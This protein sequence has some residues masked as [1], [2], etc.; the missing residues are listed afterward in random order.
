MCQT[1][2][3]S[4]MS[5]ISSLC[6]SVATT[7]CKNPVILPASLLVPNC[8]S[9]TNCNLTGWEWK[10]KKKIFDSLKILCVI[11]FTS[12]AKWENELIRSLEQFAS[13]GT[14]DVHCFSYCIDL[15]SPMKTIV[16]T[17][18][19]RF[20]RVKQ[21]MCFVDTLSLYVP[22]QYSQSHD[23]KD[24]IRESYS[25]SI[26][27]VFLEHLV[28]VPIP[29]SESHTPLIGSVWNSC[30]CPRNILLCQGENRITQTTAKTHCTTGWWVFRTAQDRFW[31]TKI[32]GSSAVLSV[33]RWFP[34]KIPI[35]PP[36]ISQL[37]ISISAIKK[38]TLQTSN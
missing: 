10:V 23:M 20:A 5:L 34:L 8:T 12:L 22:G 29:H 38:S 36:P 33:Y 3:E 32:S 13:P 35:F 28:E 18:G 11:V 37:T 15:V 2:M 9:S 14:T 7:A 19:S 1:F 21:K 27:L 25:F 30:T 4:E 6:S 17:R 16:W 24:G 26:W 31:K